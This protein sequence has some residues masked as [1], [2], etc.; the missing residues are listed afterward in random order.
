MAIKLLSLK[1][2]HN[3]LICKTFLLLQKADILF[4]CNTCSFCTD[5]SEH[6]V[7]HLKFHGDP[8]SILPCI[9]CDFGAPDKLNMDHHLLHDHHLAHDVVNQ[10]CCCRTCQYQQRRSP[11]VALED[12]R[13]PNQVRVD[14][15][16]SPS[17]VDL[18]YKYHIYLFLLKIIDK[19]IFIHKY[20]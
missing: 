10:V 4:Y 2:L 3:S 18:V 15:S 9:L 6:L 13:R 19:F 16:K 14:K 17:I 8:E 1:S 5:H 7:E 11:A 20:S 12:Q